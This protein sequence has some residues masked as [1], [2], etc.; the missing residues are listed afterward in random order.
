MRRLLEHDSEVEDAN[1]TGSASSMVSTENHQD[2]ARIQL[3]SSAENIISHILNENYG[4]KDKII[5]KTFTI[6]TIVGA[7]NK[8]RE[9][10]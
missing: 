3:D 6:H 4:I 9:K 7:L 8:K 2:R 1:T 10:R 5:M